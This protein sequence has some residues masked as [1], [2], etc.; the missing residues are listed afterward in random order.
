[1]TQESL[2]LGTFERWYAAHE[3]GDLAQLAA[4]L[5]PDVTVYSMF[6]QVPVHSRES[7]VRHFQGTMASFPD[8]SM[9]VVSGPVAARNGTVLAEACFTGSFTGKLAWRGIVYEG[10]GQSFDVPGAIVVGTTGGAVTT[11]RTLFDRDTWL[12]QIGVTDEAAIRA[13]GGGNSASEGT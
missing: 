3:R 2:A 13:G 12:R 11:V 6:R 7:A 10:L 5:A 9:P 1:V 8:L 4:V